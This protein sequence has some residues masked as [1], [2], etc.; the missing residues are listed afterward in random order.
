MKST[1]ILQWTTIQKNAI[2]KQT[3]WLTWDNLTVSILNKVWQFHRMFRWFDHD[4]A[5][6]FPSIDPNHLLYPLQ[7]IWLTS[8]KQHKNRKLA[9]K[10]IVNNKMQWFQRW[11]R[12]YS[13]MA[14]SNRMVGWKIKWNRLQQ[15]TTNKF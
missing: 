3:C 13:P 10:Q 12:L 4:F 2:T 6:Y 5:T 1:T 8:R 7:M 15:G 9:R 14:F 11:K